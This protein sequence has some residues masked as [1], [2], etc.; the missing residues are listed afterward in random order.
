MNKQNIIEELSLIIRLVEDK[1]DK[2]LLNRCINL[3]SL[4]EYEF[5]AGDYY[6]Q[7]ILNY[8]RDEN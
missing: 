1:D 2:Q 3:M 6:Y 8:I 4:I 5:G 7:E